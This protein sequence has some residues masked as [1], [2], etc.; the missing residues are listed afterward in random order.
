MVYK[1]IKTYKKGYLNVGDGHSI[2]YEL[3]GNQKGK[4][5]LFVHGGPGGGFSEKDKRFFNPKFTY[6]FFCSIPK[7]KI[8]YN[9]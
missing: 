1:N 3:S 5:V 6:F 2:Y 8:I 4:P 7:D 9:A